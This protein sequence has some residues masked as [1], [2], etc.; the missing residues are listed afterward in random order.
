MSGDGLNLRGG[1]KKHFVGS[2][3]IN[4]YQHTAKHLILGGAL[5]SGFDYDDKRIDM[6]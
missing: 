6:G 3:G 2:Q 5:L 4:H 1:E